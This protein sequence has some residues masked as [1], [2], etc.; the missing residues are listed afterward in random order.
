MVADRDQLPASRGWDCV[1][2]LKRDVFG[3]VELLRGP[4]GLCVRRVACGNGWPGTRWIARLLLRREV[5]ALA[6]L[7]GLAAVP[8]LLAGDSQASGELL[9]SW[10]EGEPLW[11]VR[12]LPQDFFDRLRDLVLAMHVRQVCHND[13]HKENNILVDRE[14]LP[15][16]LDFQLASVHPRGGWRFRRRSAEDLRHVEKHRRRYEPG[17]SGQER[18]TRPIL[19][20]VWRLAVKPVYNLITRRLFGH[21][22]GEP[23]RPREGPWPV[24]TPPVGTSGQGQ[25]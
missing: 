12:E 9:R 10:C 21:G 13:L 19:A 8:Q 20:R 5:R 16:L 25:H 7:S 6:I 17:T 14:G 18:T 3:R 4:A 1:R 24:R 23:R 11:A 22:R 15:R 2:E